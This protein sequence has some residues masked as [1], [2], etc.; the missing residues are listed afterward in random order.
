MV[1]IF[2]QIEVDLV[3]SYNMN[4]FQITLKTLSFKL[5]SW[6]KKK[7]IALY[8]AYVELPPEKCPVCIS[9]KC[10]NKEERS[11]SSI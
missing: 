5:L 11:V 3:L 6:L 4:V 2:L 7:G 10:G 9:Y 8:L 1:F